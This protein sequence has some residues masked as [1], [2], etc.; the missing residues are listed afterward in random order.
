MSDKEKLIK[1]FFEKVYGKKYQE[2]GLKNLRHDGREGH[3][4]EEQLSIKAN[5]NTAPDILGYE[6][7]KETSSKTTFGDWSPDKKI[8]GRNFE[9]EPDLTVINRNDFLKIFGQPNL[10]KNGRCSWSGKPAPKI[11]KFNDFGQKLHIDES[12]NIQVIYS[13]IH[14]NRYNKSEITPR[15][16]QDKTY[17]I[18]QWSAHKLKQKLLS[19]FGQKGWVKAHKNSNGYYT[20]LAFGEPL[21]YKSW[22]QDIR[23]GIVFF[24]PGMY[25]GN[26]RPYCQWRSIN[27]DWDSNTVEIVTYD[28]FLKVKNK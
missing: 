11:N 12:G 15:Q 27:K 8:W 9:L 28:D 14:D 22:L 18:A 3:W 16:F 23:N 10:E 24:D 13:Y 5:G 4:L 7:K 1:L 21:T 2:N 17:V 19:K 20:H 26:S 6:L 25:Q